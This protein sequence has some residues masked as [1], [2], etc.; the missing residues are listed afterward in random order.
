MAVCDGASDCV[1]EKRCHRDSTEDLL[2]RDFI[3][4]IKNTSLKP[5]IGEMEAF[6][7]ILW[8]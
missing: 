6:F 8:P 4:K 2:R 3:T 5:V 7:S 1:L